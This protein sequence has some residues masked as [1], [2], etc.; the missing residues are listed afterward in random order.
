MT[1]PHAVTG[2]DPLGAAPAGT[3][4]DGEPML[5]VRDLEVTYPDGSR[6][7]RG[8]DLDVRSGTCLAVL[9]ES[10]CGKSTLLSAL[11]G[12]LPRHT[13]TSGSVRIGGAETLGASER[14]L[15]RVRRTRLG[16]VPQDPFAAVD[17]LRPVIHHLR[18]AARAAGVHIDETQAME[19]LA[20]LGLDPAVITAR[21]WPHQWSGGML[22]RAC[23]AAAT[24]AD[25]PLVLADEPTS[26]LDPDTAEA[27]LRDLRA[28]S[29]SLVLVT[30]DLTAAALV[31]DEVAVLYAGRIV[32][33]G[34]ATRV[35]SAPRHPYTAALLAASP[36]EPGTMPRPL[37]G[38]P[39]DPRTDPAGCA[40]RT[41]C[42]RAQDDCAI[43]PPAAAV[44]CHHP[45]PGGR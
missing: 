44:A 18:F 4:E 43:P 38:T 35:L 40:F 21:K 5:S 14:T 39:P 2:P 13:R 31:A 33:R 10:G 15:R 8:I 25:P 24:I 1:A 17:P 11:L 12:L 7:L 26:A 22:Q 19:R 42:P 3:V 36:R 34:P 28:R 23:I 20:A 9:G 30:H 16:F 45:E 6:G 27:V 41:R 29:G 32:E 37:P